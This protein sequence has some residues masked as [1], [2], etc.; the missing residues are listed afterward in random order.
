LFRHD[1][2]H[3]EHG[4]VLGGLTGSQDFVDLADGGRPATPE[5]GQDIELGVGRFRKAVILHIRRTY[6]DAIRMSS[7]IFTDE[8]GNRTIASP[9]ARNPEATRAP[10]SS[11]DR[12]S[13]ASAEAP[14]PRYR[15][16][17][18]GPWSAA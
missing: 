11:A 15:D 13:P 1:L 9:P 3:L 2:Q 5:H 10:A 4:S 12:S 8:G 14:P 17:A 6:Y 7:G 18:D 16:M